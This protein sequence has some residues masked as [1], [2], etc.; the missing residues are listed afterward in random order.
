MGAFGANSSLK[1][2]TFSGEEVH[3]VEEVEGNQTEEEDKEKTEDEGGG[4]YNHIHF[5]FL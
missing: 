2:K 5:D 3:K 1:L 4:A